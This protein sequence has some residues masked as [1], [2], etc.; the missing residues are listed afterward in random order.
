MPGRTIDVRT[1]TCCVNLVNE[2]SGLKAHKTL[3]PANIRYARRQ[4]MWGGKIGLLKRERF[5]TANTTEI[6]AI[7]GQ[8]IL[9]GMPGSAST[10]FWL[11]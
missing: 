11:K 3:A 6:A 9:F 2:L 1:I 7:A 4:M 5:R 10:L 8:K